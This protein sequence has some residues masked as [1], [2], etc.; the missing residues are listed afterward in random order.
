MTDEE[1][2]QQPTKAEASTCPL[3]NEYP[4]TLQSREPWFWFAGCAESGSTKNCRKGIT[5]R[6][7]AIQER[8]GETIETEE[9][10][11]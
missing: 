9:D 7:Y 11:Q 10:L 6:L 3:C 4:L 8:I 2:E 1:K 5:A